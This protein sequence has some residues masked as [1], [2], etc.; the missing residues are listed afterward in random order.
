MNKFTTRVQL[1]GYPTEDQYNRL[2]KAMSAKGF[3]RFI[4]GSDGETYHLPHAE[5]NRAVN[6]TIEQVRN[7]AVAAAA[8]VSNDYQV[9]VTEGTRSWQGLKKATRSELAVG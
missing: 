6:V 4:Q 2:H 9:L 5:Y 3:S 7:D 1:D 8:T